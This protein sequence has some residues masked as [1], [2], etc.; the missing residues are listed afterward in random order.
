[1]ARA[2]PHPPV[3]GS[4]A[5]TFPTP[6]GHG[7]RRGWWGGEGALPPLL[8]LLAAAAAVASATAPAAA[9]ATAGA[10]THRGL[11]ARCAASRSGRSPTTAGC[12]CRPAARRQR[13]YGDA[14]MR[15]TAVGMGMEWR[16]ICVTQPSSS[17]CGQAALGRTS[18]FYCARAAARLPLSPAPPHQ[19]P[20]MHSLLP[21]LPPLRRRDGGAAA[22][23]LTAAPP[24]RPASPPAPC[25]ALSPPA[26]GDCAQ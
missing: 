18:P 14:D 10:A 12:A 13:R 15:L 1:M 20:A 4:T 25:F 21:L 8:Q 24:L 17:G 5:P 11:A 23:T 26:R 9:A 3:G 2:R 6:T 7:A 19:R 22:A 16:D